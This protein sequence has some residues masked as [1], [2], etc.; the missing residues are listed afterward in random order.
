MTGSDN[1]APVGPTQAADKAASAART[2]A[3]FDAM[4]AQA[5][6]IKTIDAEAHVDRHAMVITSQTELK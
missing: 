6:R 2:K 5:A 1:A 3:Q 4:R